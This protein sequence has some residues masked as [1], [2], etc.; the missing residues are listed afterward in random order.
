MHAE[1]LVADDGCKRQAVE[2]F[3]KRLPNI[4]MSVLLAAFIVESICLRNGQCLVIAS[5]QRDPIPVPDFQG[6]QKGKGLNGV[7]ALMSRQI[8]LFT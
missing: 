8:P 7:E 4:G 6:Q 2:D 5:Q 3:C 1:D